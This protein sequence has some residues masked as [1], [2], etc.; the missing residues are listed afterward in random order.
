M[1][2]I[3]YQ[4]DN[5][6]PTPL[7]EERGFTLAANPSPNFTSSLLQGVVVENTKTATMNIPRP[8]YTENL[9]KGANP[10]HFGFARNLRQHLTNA[11]SLLWTE[12]RG[13]K[14]A[15]AKIRRQHPINSFIADFYCHEAALVIE[16]DGAVHNQ[17]EQTEYDLNR[18]Y[19]LA[20]LGIR[21]IRF[22]NDEVEKNMT[23]VLQV[24]TK[25]LTPGPS[26]GGE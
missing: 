3:R 9:F 7:L 24:I 16:L 18:T 8:D 13:R 6:T 20:E 5:L 12:V 21:V 11:E 1:R 19:V 14:I 26:S 15:G 17:V 10:K 4:R 2:F 22:T 23:W 25:Y